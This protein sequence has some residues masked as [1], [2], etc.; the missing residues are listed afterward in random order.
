M[1]NPER[2]SQGTGGTGSASE[3]REAIR[4]VR[5]SLLLLLGV[6]VVGTVGYMLLMGWNLLDALYMTTITIGTIGYEEVRDLSADPVGRL[7]TM[8]LIIAG[9]GSL[10]YTA[11]T[12]AQFIVEGTIGGYFGRRRMEGK[13]EK[14]SGHYI[15]CG[16]GRVGREIAEE[17]AS[18]GVEFVVIDQDESNSEECLRKGYL[19][20]LGDASRDEVLEASGVRRA[21]G[22]VAAVDSDADNMFVVVS[23]RELNPDLYIVARAESDES[24]SKL[25][26]AGADR[27]LS[28]YAV[29][30]RRLARLTTHPLLVDY[31]DIISRSGEGL[32]FRLEEFE[33]DDASPLV[34]CSVRQLRDAEE[35]TGAKVLAIR[36]KNGGFNTTPSGRDKVLAGDILIVLGTHDQVTRMEGMIED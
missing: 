12:V 25:K 28:P 19:N 24:L 27:T 32:E 6:T 16:Y 36:H 29:G 18:G 21:K 30:G 20:L 3:P 31:L 35:E 15:L 11:S 26:R 13:I 22:L 4:R 14:L 17:F 34:N 9:V 2:P 7:W 5:R 33:V 23:A 1:T 10:A 8:I